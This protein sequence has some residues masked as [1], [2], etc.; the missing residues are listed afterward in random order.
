MDVHS[1]GRRLL[2]A[3]DDVQEC[4]LATARSPDEADE[5]AS[6][7][8]HGDAVEGEQRVAPLAKDL[9]DLLQPYRGLTRIRLTRV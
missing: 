5:F 7:D 1:P 9:A 8:L 6:P 3:G 4:R 2:Q